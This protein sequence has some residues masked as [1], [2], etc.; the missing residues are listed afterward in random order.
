MKRPPRPAA[1]LGLLLVV[2]AAACGSGTEQPTANPTNPVVTA[3]PDTA[4]PRLTPK[5]TLNVGLC[6]NAAR[7]FAAWNKTA[8]TS[9]AN[10]TA[11]TPDDV[12]ALKAAAD[13]YFDQT[14]GYP[15]PAAPAFTVVVGEYRVNLGMF[16]LGV[17]TLGQADPELARVAVESVGK[18]R[19][20]YKAFR[21]AAECQT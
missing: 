16:A 15:D 12:E 21:T 11:A 14:K 5:A 1:L 4:R 13:E 20:A 3:G 9:S 19:D 2:F 18:V 6:A 7:H 8:P 17:I 10:L